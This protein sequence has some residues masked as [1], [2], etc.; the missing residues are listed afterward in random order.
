MRQDRERWTRALR[1][2]KTSWRKVSWPE[3]SLREGEQAVWAARDSC[4]EAMNSK[5]RTQQTWGPKQL[6]VRRL[7]APGTESEP[8]PKNTPSPTDSQ[9]MP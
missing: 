6:C 2:K 9:A 1:A 4:V 3:A 5:Q 8:C 7:G